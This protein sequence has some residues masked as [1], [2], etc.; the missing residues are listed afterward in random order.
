MV[1]TMLRRISMIVNTVVKNIFLAGNIDPGD[2][3]ASGA[4]RRAVPV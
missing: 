3:T 4:G 1:T 2:Q